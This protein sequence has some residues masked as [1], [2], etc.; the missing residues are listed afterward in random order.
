MS[1]LLGNWSDAQMNR[2]M[3]NTELCGRLEQDNAELARSRQGSLASGAAHLTEAGG[4]RRPD[5][6]AVAGPAPPGGRRPSGW[7]AAT[8]GS[9]EPSRQWS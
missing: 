8:S 2:A 4:S 6:A 7:S 1:V 3:G 5:V 9:S